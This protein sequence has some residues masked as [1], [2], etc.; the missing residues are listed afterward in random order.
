MGSATATAASSHPRSHGPAAFTASHTAA[1]K[2]AKE[3][4]T[5]GAAYK[6]DDCT[7]KAPAD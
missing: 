2:L 4:P 3:W 1:A 5:S 6:G 7:A